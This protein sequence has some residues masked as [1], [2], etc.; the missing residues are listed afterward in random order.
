MAEM[1]G[2]AV[3]DPVSDLERGLP[4]LC[5]Q[6]PQIRGH[7]AGR[8]IGQYRKV[9]TIACDRGATCGGGVIWGYSSALSFLSIRP[10]RPLSF[11]TFSRAAHTAKPANHQQILE[12]IWLV[13]TQI[14]S[15]A[16]FCADIISDPKAISD[17]PSGFFANWRVC[18]SLQPSGGI[19]NF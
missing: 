9:G 7:A 19:R 8:H 14:I 18:P 15:T 16:Y 10:I 17:A 13:G 3:D 1:A 12:I 6:H 2:F 11:I 4:G 5:G